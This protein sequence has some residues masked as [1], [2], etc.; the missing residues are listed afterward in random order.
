MML[1]GWDKKGALNY[2]M[3]IQRVHALLVKSSAWA[4]DPFMPP[5]LTD[6]EAY[7]LGRS[8]YAM[9][10]TEPILV[11]LSGFITIYRLDTH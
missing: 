1:A 9:Q 2:T 8:Q 5:D 7:D 11:V 6:E 4:Q 10:L 3:W